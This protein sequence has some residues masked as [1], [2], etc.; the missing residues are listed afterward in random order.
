[1]QPANQYFIKKYLT[2]VISAMKLGILIKRR[3]YGRQ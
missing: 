1:V 3:V 2:L